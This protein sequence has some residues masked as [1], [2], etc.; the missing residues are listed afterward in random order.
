MAGWFVTVILMVA[1][2]RLDMWVKERLQHEREYRDKRLQSK[3]S[4]FPLTKAISEAHDD[5]KPHHFSNETNLLYRIVLGMTAKQYKEKH[6]V[7][8]V[9]DHLSYEQLSLLSDLQVIDTGF[10]MLD[11]P[12]QIRKQLLSAHFEGDSTPFLFQANG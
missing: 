11:I 7:S 1:A 10:L 8:S 12:Y 6:G 5:L 9:K 2:T 4:Y 3:T